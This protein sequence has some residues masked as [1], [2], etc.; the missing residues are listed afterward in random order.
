VDAREVAEL[1]LEFVLN[2]HRGLIVRGHIVSFDDPEKMRADA[3]RM[4]IC[5]RR[6]GSSYF[7]DNR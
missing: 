4:A 5:I 7:E 1:F 2:V 6:S 3:V